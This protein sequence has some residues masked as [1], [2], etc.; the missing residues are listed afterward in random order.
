MPDISGR[1]VITQWTE[2]LLKLSI[3][4][5]ITSS[6]KVLSPFQPCP[7]IL[8]TCRIVDDPDEKYLVNTSNGEI[9]PVFRK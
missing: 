7:D 4:K 3:E 9:I 8:K 2:I 6:Y 5:L 1:K